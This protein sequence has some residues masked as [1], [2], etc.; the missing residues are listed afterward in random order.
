MNQRAEP[1]P[2]RHQTTPK[3]QPLPQRRASTITNRPRNS[4]HPEVYKDLVYDKDG[5]LSQEGKD[6]LVNEVII[7]FGGKNKV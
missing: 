2:T 3:L 5:I 6:E 4:T 1:Y 7:H